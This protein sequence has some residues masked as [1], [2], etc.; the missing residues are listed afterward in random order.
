MRVLSIA[1][2][3]FMISGT[4]AAFA[5][6]LNRGLGFNKLLADRDA[7]N[8]YNPFASSMPSEL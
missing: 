8:L 3:V 5:R 1:Q 2:P 7:D 6:A 4:V